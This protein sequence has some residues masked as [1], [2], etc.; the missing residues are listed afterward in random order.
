MDAR[1]RAEL[2]FKEIAAARNKQWYQKDLETSRVNAR[3]K[4]KSGREFINDLKHGRACADCGISYPTHMLDFDHV[5]GEKIANVSKM[6]NWN[7]EK[8]L[9]EIAKCDIVCA[10]CHRDRTHKRRYHV[11][12]SKAA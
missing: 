4:A 10:N 11:K 9:A 6:H 8:I 12:Q 5:H 3:R 2:G 7:Q 1:R